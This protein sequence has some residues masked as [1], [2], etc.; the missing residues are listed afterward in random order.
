MA[1]TVIKACPLDTTSPRETKTWSTTPGMGEDA[2]WFASTDPEVSWAWI[3]FGSGMFNVVT[4]SGPN[5]FK[6]CIN[7]FKKN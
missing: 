3:H 1:I 7:F 4:P 6:K 5:T 2:N